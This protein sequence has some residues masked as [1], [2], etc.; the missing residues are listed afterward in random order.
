MARGTTVNSMKD[1]TTG[2]ERLST[3]VRLK[4]HRRKALKEGY[5]VQ[6]ELL[7]GVRGSGSV[8][9]GSS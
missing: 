6:R 2:Q 1:R 3:V 4:G 7:D 9:R 5:Q 8:R